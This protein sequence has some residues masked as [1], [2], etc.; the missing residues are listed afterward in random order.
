MGWSRPSDTE[1]PC[2]KIWQTDW[3][4]FELDHQQQQETPKQ[5]WPFPGYSHGALQY[6]T[7]LNVT[8]SRKNHLRFVLRLNPSRFLMLY[9]GTLHT[10]SDSDFLVSPSPSHQIRSWICLFVSEGTTLIVYPAYQTWE[11]ERQPLRHLKINPKM[12]VKCNWFPKSY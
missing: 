1:I 10:R 12:A 2:G 11:V 4:N 3:V 8:P 6:L 7:M 5:P 9:E